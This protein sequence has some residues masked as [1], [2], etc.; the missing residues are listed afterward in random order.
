MRLRFSSDTPSSTS[1]SAS[2]V[3]DGFGERFG[4]RTLCSRRGSGECI[5]ADV[6]EEVGVPRH[7]GP[8][9]LQLRRQCTC[10]CR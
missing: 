4:E 2:D 5:G 6:L 10:E 9:W 7:D 8:V 3:G 1:W